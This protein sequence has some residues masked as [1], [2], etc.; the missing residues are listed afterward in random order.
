M[1]GIS[2]KAN[3]Y[4]SKLFLACGVFFIL[5][6]NL[7][8]HTLLWKIHLGQDFDINAID[9]IENRKQSSSE[10]Q[11][12][13]WSLSDSFFEKSRED[14]VLSLFNRSAL[15]SYSEQTFRSSFSIPILWLDAYGD[16]RWNEAAHRELFS[17]LLNKQTIND[18]ISDDQ[19]ID[20]CLQRS[21]FV[22]NQNDWGFFSRYHCFI[23]QFGQTL[24]SPWMTLLSYNR[25]RVS[26]AN[27]ED[28]LDEGILRYFEPISTC[29][30]Y[31]R[32]ERMKPIESRLRKD[33]RDSLEV[34]DISQLL[35]RTQIKNGKVFSVLDTS[36]VWT[37]GYEHIP[38]RR[39]MFSYTRFVPTYN[40]SIK[41]LTNHT[42]EHIYRAPSLTEDFLTQ[43][44]P[45]NKPVNQ[46]Q[47][48]LTGDQYKLTWQ[49]NVFTGFLRY[50]FVL[51][52]HRFAPRIHKMTRLLAE[53]WSNYIADKY[54]RSLNDTSAIFIRRGDKMP[55]DSFWQKH[56][57]WRNIS[58]YVKGLV[59]E[60]K[61]QNRTFSS[62]FVMTDDALVMKS[63]Q[64]Y[65]DP[66]SN[67]TDE[68]YAREHLRN[69]QIMYNVFA[70][71]ACFDPFIRI[72]FDQFL[73]S[74][75]FIVQHAQFTIGHSDSNVGRYLE[76][77]TYSRHQL[78]ASVHS[79]SFVKNAPDSL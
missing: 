8:Y 57:R 50:M 79:D 49:D 26:E 4:R 74:L 52:F 19:I 69:R 59:D 24:Y 9:N 67:G 39:W 14:D 64:D 47:H 2:R 31:A 61:Q 38:L 6:L 11:P 20:S 22:I 45:R 1:S 70:P 36:R 34:T 5:L 12:D 68:P 44:K 23:E 15:L 37:F 3:K 73:V 76:E 65:S 28:F 71:Q 30:K 35:Y 51:Y 10:D 21:F 56:K 16:V 17:Y 48:H 53:H 32:H 25:F 75:E 63:I 7:S 66:K 43:W 46:P 41:F 27:R 58:L 18:K 54:G 40:L 72:G 60:E 78:N 62:V 42:E 13:A 29:S 33:N 55:E 77:I